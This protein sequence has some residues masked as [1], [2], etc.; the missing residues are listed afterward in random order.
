M[1]IL[2]DIVF[3]FEAERAHGRGEQPVLSCRYAAAF[4]CGTLHAVAGRSG[5]GKTT[6]LYLLA[7]FYKAQSG[8]ITL[9]GMPIQHLP[10]RKRPV[11]MLFQENNLFAHLT[12]RENIAVGICGKPRADKGLDARIT[13]A[14]ERA[15]IAALGAELPENLSGGEKKRTALVRSLMR[16]EMLYNSSGGHICPLLLLDEPFNELDMH[17]K[18]QFKSL[19]VSAPVLKNA[20]I[21]YTAHQPEDILDTAERLYVIEAADG[22]ARI[23]ENGTPAELRRNNTSV[24][25][26]LCTGGQ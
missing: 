12:A 18:A 22:E 3:R 8:Q 19:L 2:N 17:A 26:R 5:A 7:G 16:A 14:M 15:G 6:L 24:F 1:L 21:I 23:A 9:N 10:A 20:V 11:S 4:E 25:S 13:E